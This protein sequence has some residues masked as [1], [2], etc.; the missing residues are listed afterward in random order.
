MARKRDSSTLISETIKRHSST[1]KLETVYLVC[2]VRLVYLVCLVYLI[3]CAIRHT[4]LALMRSVGAIVDAHGEF[5]IHRL[6][7]LHLGIK[8]PL[9]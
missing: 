3:V 4:P 7:A 6:V 5:S 1:V 2:P 8:S 9:A